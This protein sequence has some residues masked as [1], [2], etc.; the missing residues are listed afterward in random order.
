MIE[1]QKKRKEKKI[2]ERELTLLLTIIIIIEL[3]F[4]RI[5]KKNMK[6]HCTRLK[7]A[8]DKTLKEKL[9]IW[10]VKDHRKAIKFRIF[11]LALRVATCILYIVEVLLDPYSSNYS[12]TTSSSQKFSSNNNNINNNNVNNR[13]L[14]SQ[15]ASLA[16]I[17]YSSHLQPLDQTFLVSDDLNSLNN[18]S[19][20]TISILPDQFGDNGEINW[21]NIVFV[22]RHP[23]V[24][25]LQL[26]FAVYGFFETFFYFYLCYNVSV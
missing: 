21:Q 25:Y 14:Q 26:V 19:N 17:H 18:L 9:Q 8:S 20:S 5:T 22:R 15:I 13:D 1:E 10:F 11:N 7:Y 24:R 2:T 12:S 4:L 16:S 3:N 6:V 23:I